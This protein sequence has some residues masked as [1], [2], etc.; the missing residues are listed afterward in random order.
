MMSNICRR[1]QPQFSVP[2]AGPCVSRL[3]ARLSVPFSP[4]LGHDAW[5]R[6]ESIRGHLIWLKLSYLFVYYMVE[7]QKESFFYSHFFKNIIFNF[8]E[9]FI[10]FTVTCCGGKKNSQHHR[11]NCLWQRTFFLVG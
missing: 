5:L 1:G 3:S 2:D 11:D 4:C 10:D 9:S 8:F 6:E 7:S